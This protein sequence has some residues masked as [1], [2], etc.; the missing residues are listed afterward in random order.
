ML[1]WI[2]DST[3]S[4]KQQSVDSKTN[5][6]SWIFDSTSSLKQQSVDRHIAP[7]GTDYSDIE[8]TSI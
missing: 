4:L 5:T 1:S 2:F 8:P 7:L 3:S 6:L